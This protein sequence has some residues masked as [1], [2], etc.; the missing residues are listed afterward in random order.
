MAP[1]HPDVLD[2]LSVH[3]SLVVDIA[4]LGLGAAR[5]LWWLHETRHV[6]RIA[7]PSTTGPRTRNSRHA[8]RMN[9][10]TRHVTRTPELSPTDEATGVP[11]G[12]QRPAAGLR[13]RE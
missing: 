1:V 11:V 8:P 2:Q 5:S 7:T 9:R 4:K 13:H 12:R 6:R 10:T 3:C